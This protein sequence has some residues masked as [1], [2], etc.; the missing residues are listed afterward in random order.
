MLALV[1]LADDCGGWTVWLIVVDSFDV[2]S[3]CLPNNHQVVVR[4]PSHTDC[5]DSIPEQQWFLLTDPQRTCLQIPIISPENKICFKVQQSALPPIPSHL[6]HYIVITKYMYAWS[7]MWC[8]I[9]NIGWVLLLLPNMLATIGKTDLPPLVQVA[10]SYRQ[11]LI[12]CNICHFV[13]C[14]VWQPGSCGSRFPYYLRGEQPTGT[15][16]ETLEACTSDTLTATG[17]CV[18]QM[19]IITFP[20]LSVLQY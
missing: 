20:T 2:D 13:C 8:A 9:S 16:Q 6:T 15:A 1:I 3:P 19:F 18:P 4:D 17:T 7:Y 5:D 12:G 10:Q 14:S 11:A